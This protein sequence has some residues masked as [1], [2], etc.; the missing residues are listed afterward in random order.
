MVFDAILY[1]PENWAKIEKIEMS[2]EFKY[3]WVY[4]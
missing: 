2:L 3:L 1:L 4:S